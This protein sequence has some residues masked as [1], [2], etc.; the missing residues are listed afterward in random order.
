MRITWRSWQRWGSARL[1]A[2]C[3]AL[4][5]ACSGSISP[6]YRYFE[7]PDPEDLWS[8]SIGHWQARAL[9][10][11]E[12]QAPLPA[13]VAGAE[14]DG[15]TE[16]EGPMPEVAAAP[17]GFPAFGQ[18]G[19][20]YRAFQAEQKR[21]QAR[22]LVR[23]LQHQAKLHFQK[24]GSVDQWPTLG[25]LL[26]RDADD[27]DGLE[28]L[29]YYF[30]QEM[31]LPRTEI[32]RAVVY[33]LRDHQHHMVTLWF[34]DPNDPWVLDSTGAMATRLTRMSEIPGW[35]PLKIFSESEE[36]T[37]TPIDIASGPPVP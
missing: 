17:A 9:A 19:H 22:Q 11:R 5:C 28:L 26:A 33:R 10:E 18:L 37:V 34:E 15:E 21:V 13:P 23:W 30:L 29:S 4:L 12:A 6:G 36:Y 8:E 32:F 7:L 27:C 16:V 2:S 1:L 31:G 25:Q 3:A 35:V 14:A 20:S 24:D